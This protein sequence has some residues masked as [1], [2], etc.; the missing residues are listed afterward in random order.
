MPDV[1]VS[2]RNF[3]KLEQKYENANNLVKKS[4]TELHK[5]RLRNAKQKLETARNIMNQNINTPSSSKARRTLTKS[6]TYISSKKR[7]PS[8][9]QYRKKLEKANAEILR[10][11]KELTE[12]QEKIA[13][14][15]KELATMKFQNKLLVNNNR[16]I[17]SDN[18]SIISKQFTFS[19]I[20]NTSN[21]QYLCGLTLP[22]F[23]ML[24]DC[25]MPYFHLIPY[26]DCCHTPSLNRSLDKATELLAVLTICRH[27]VHQG[28]MAFFMDISKSTM[29]RI[30]IGWVIFVAGIF[31]EIDLK[32]PSGFL[33]KKMPK[34]FIGLVVYY[35]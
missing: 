29:Q 25:L 31:N 15:N 23:N 21:F 4:A 32:P 30:F 9:L 1:V 17:R 34:S 24:L 7:N 10:L 5:K 22:Q 27:G 11:N 8:K 33:L 20:K 12:S 28:L 26:P 16:K 2:E 19:N 14:L 35:Q 3:Q 6:S 18:M 13:R